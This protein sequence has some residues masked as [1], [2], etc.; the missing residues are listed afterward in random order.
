MHSVDRSDAAYFP[1]EQDVHALEPEN[2]NVPF[3]Q[4]S[5]PVAPSVEA[6]DLAPASRRGEFVVYPAC[7]AASRREK[8]VV[9]GR[10]KWRAGVCGAADS[11]E[12]R[13][14]PVKPSKP[15]RLGARLYK[16]LE[17]LR[18]LVCYY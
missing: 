14:S 18:N 9:Y 8:V 6:S 13:L 1:A 2:E 10:D 11:A 15:S 3:G 16:I 12:I 7:A 5:C 17:S 4:G